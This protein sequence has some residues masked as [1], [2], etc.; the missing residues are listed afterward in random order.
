MQFFFFQA[1][2]GIRDGHVTGVQTC[3]LPIYPA[4]AEIVEQSSL[5]L[6]DS[7]RWDEGRLGIGPP[8]IGAQERHVGDRAHLRDP[9][10][11]LAYITWALRIADAWRH[12]RGAPDAGRLT[13]LADRIHSPMTADGILST[14]REGPAM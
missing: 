2:D 1:D 9:S 4:S 10:F 8:V 6:V 13:A 14:F 12:R 3:A 5:F 7:L 11:E